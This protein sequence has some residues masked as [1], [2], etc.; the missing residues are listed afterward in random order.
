MRKK[1]NR[2]RLLF[3]EIRHFYRLHLH[4]RPVNDLS[5]AVKLTDRLLHFWGLT[6]G[7]FTTKEYAVRLFPSGPN[8]L[9]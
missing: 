8:L 4:H 1:S 3:E 6:E 5:T 7:L 9:L 2:H